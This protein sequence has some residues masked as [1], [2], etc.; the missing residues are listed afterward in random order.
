MD[1]E[2][3]IS[4]TKVRTIGKPRPVDKLLLPVE[5]NGSKMC[6]STSGGIPGP[7]SFTLTTTSDSFLVAA[8]TM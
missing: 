6:A 8:T 2:P 5:K 1:T 7:S 3:P 4:W